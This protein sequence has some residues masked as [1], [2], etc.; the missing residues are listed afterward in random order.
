MHVARGGSA[1]KRWPW[2]HTATDEEAWRFAR[3][4]AGTNAAN[5]VGNPADHRSHSALNQPRDDFP[6]ALNVKRPRP[7]LHVPT[8]ITFTGRQTDLR[9]SS[10]LC[11]AFGNLHLRGRPLRNTIANSAPNAFQTNTNVVVLASWT[12]AFA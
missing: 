4:R 7:L 11:F 8:T 1:S 5:T 12:A 10:S 3:L 6:F 2:R 9:F